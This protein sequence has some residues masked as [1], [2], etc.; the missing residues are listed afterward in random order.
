MYQENSSL[1]KIGQKGQALDLA[2]S[3]V[4]CLTYNIPYGLPSDGTRHLIQVDHMTFIQVQMSVL[5]VYPLHDCTI[6]LT[7]KQE[8][9]PELHCS[10]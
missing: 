6:F 10:T 4:Q 3:H 9:I 7:V 5:F 2:S 8:Y 1:A